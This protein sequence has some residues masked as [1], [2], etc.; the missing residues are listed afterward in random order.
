MRSKLTAEWIKAIGDQKTASWNEV[1]VA[2]REFITYLDTEL[3]VFSDGEAAKIL[4]ATLARRGKSLTMG[5]AILACQ[6]DSVSLESD[7]RE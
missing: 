2:L 7:L 5:K 4:C 3:P 1:R 6:Y